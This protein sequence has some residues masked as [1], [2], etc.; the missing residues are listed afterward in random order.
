[1]THQ[2]TTLVPQSLPLA[3]TQKLCLDSGSQPCHLAALSLSIFRYQGSHSI[4]GADDIGNAKCYSRAK[5]V[6]DSFHVVE[7]GV[8]DPD[9][10]TTPGPADVRFEVVEF[11]V[12]FADFAVLEPV[13]CLVHVER[14]CCN[15]TVGLIKS[16]C[17]RAGFAALPNCKP[18]WLQPCWEKAKKTLLGRKQKIN[19]ASYFPKTSPKL[20]VWFVS[21]CTSMTQ[22]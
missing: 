10:L 5:L 22:S 16:E 21:T 2:Q 8:P 9:R 3:S 15:A 7:T 20:L 14:S 4:S 18:G 11:E 6:N 1:M 12:A 19:T 17:V 13:N